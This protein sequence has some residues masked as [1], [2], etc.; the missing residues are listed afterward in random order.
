MRLPMRRRKE[1]RPLNRTRLQQLVADICDTGSSRS[2]E[3]AHGAE[4]RFTRYFCLT[5]PI[6]A[7]SGRRPLTQAA[8]AFAAQRE[9]ATMRCAYCGL[10]ADHFVPDTQQTLSVGAGAGAFSQQCGVGP[11]QPLRTKVHA[12]QLE[13]PSQAPLH[14][15]G[16]LFNG[17]EKFW[18]SEP[19][20]SLPY[21]IVC[22]HAGALRRPTAKAIALNICF[23]LRSPFRSQS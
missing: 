5:L 20:R 10:R 16:M 6:G 8:V 3:R 2:G 1:S 11:C 18:I 19:R 15:S 21:S 17:R 4:L 22:A 7:F 14:C 12:T 23:M 13:L 9:G